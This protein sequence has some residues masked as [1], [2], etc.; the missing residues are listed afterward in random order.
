M[1]SRVAFN[2]FGK[3][4]YWYGIIIALALILGVVLAI[5][6]A[7]RRGYRS[8]LILDFMLLAIPIG[9]VCARLYYVIFEWQNYSGNLL[10]VFAVWEGGLA[11][12]GAIIG[13]AIS[14][15]IFYRW[16]RVR[17]G[18]MLDIAAPSLVIAQA[19][20]RWGNY[21]NQEAHGG[22]ISNPS[23]QWFPAGVQIDGSWYQATFFYESM[24]N[25]LVFIALMAVRK[26]IKVK[27]GVFA[28]YVALYGF[29]RF[30]IESLRTDSLM[31][32]DIRV[33]Q[34]LS[35]LLF[36]GGIAYLI[37]M[38]ARKMTLKPYTG[39]YSL[40]WTPEQINDYKVNSA[41]YKARIDAEDA[42]EKAEQLKE[43]YGEESKAV[44]KALDKAENAKTKLEKLLEERGLSEDNTKDK[45]ETDVDE[46]GSVEEK[47]DDKK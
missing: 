26:K 44:E 21:V 17:I 5:I 38:R 15:I 11:I 41:V 45:P 47:D 25:V 30:W 23:W 4:I 13:G 24:W 8:E 22:L 39:Y 3:D 36:V 9:I 6:E 7:K 28:L 43:K 29:G 37:I 12:Y 42:A 27:G 33:S 18:D 2:I 34:V 46:G 40:S 31:V 20:G 19:I 14:A 1:S 32:N 10:K 16:R 35:V